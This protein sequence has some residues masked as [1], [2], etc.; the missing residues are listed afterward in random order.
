MVGLK[1]LYVYITGCI[2]YLHAG[3]VERI[4][5]RDNK[6]ALKSS[7]IQLVCEISQFSSS[8][9][10]E[11]YKSDTSL[12]SSLAGINSMTVCSQSLCL[13]TTIGRY[14]FSADNSSVYINI[15]SVNRS[16]DQ[17]WWTCSIINQRK[18]LLLNVI[19]VPTSL[20][21]ENPPS[22]NQDLALNAV[23]LKCSTG[24]SYPQPSF[25][26]YYSEPGSDSLQVWS[27]SESASDTTRGCSDSERKYSSTL[28]L[29]RYTTFTGNVQKSVQFKCSILSFTGMS[30]QL[31]TGY[32]REIQFAVQVSYATLKDGTG[33]VTGQLQVI[34][35]ISKTLTCDTSE[36]RPAATI[37]WYIGTQE[38]QRST[39]STFSF[40]PKTIDHNKTVYCKAFNIQPENQAVVSYKTILFVQERTNVKSFYIGQNESQTVATLEEHDVNIPLTCIVTGISAK[41]LYIIFNRDIIARQ[42]NTNRLEHNIQ[43]ITC[44]T[45]GI[46]ICNAVDNFGASTNKTV[47]VFVECSPRPVRQVL[48]NIT[49]EVGKS[50]TLSF[51]VIAYP[52][53]GPKGF[54]WFM[55]DRLNWISL[56]S[57]ED[58]QISSSGLET[59]LTISNVSLEHYGKYR[60]TTVN[61]IG[62]Y[63]QILFL[64]EKGFRPDTCKC[65]KCNQEKSSFT[66]S[67][68][69]GIVCVVLIG[70]GT[71]T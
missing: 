33:T 54:T 11:V 34:S 61:R 46:Y 49:S 18:D 58:L 67:I 26:W 37:V 28:S 16:A 62:V 45:G 25:T 19:T 29:P 4:Y 55:E 36:S 69:L 6:A 42:S 27:S 60:V 35:G 66:M 43:D 3:T 39:S 32:S 63:D 22:Q 13:T 50:V 20:Q 14:T 21:Y 51:M 9:T 17:K 31:Y 41:D 30:E 44:T 48:H 7:N 40:N 1:I 5:I 65:N 10:V 15:T 56:L 59:N 38:K 8:V 24:C 12:P 70:Y 64:S 47:T 68:V 57:N 23:Q 53:P 2:A 52:K 71:G